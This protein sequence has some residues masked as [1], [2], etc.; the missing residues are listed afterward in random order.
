MAS[1][2]ANTMKP[3]G[4]AAAPK[5]QKLHHFSERPG[6]LPAPR[7]PCRAHQIIHCN[8]CS[9]E[10][11]SIFPSNPW[12]VD[13]YL[14][15]ITIALIQVQPALE[16]QTSLSEKK[17]HLQYIIFSQVS[18]PKKM[19][20]VC[21]VV[22]LGDCDSLVNITAGYLPAGSGTSHP[23]QLMESRQKAPMPCS[24]AK[25]Q[26]W[27]ASQG[28]RSDLPHPSPPGCFKKGTCGR[29]VDKSQILSFFFGSWVLN[30]PMAFGRLVFVT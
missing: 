18:P 13:T 14:D 9:Q 12:M 17:M 29:E 11:C 2:Q 6:T 26:V 19:H 21:R 15:R 7:A 8:T 30:N 10:N 27:N 16:A 23:S 3:C 24:C 28:P 4:A 1:P 5:T 22:P 20:T 25:G